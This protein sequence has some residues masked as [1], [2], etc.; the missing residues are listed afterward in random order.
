VLIVSFSMGL[1]AVLIA[2]GM[3][4]LYARRIVERFEWKGGMIAKL[5][6][7]SPVA[8]VLFGGIIAVQSA[9][10]GKLWTM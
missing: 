4:M 7:A 8:I 3:T 5:Q 9:M 6:L 2:I 1:A 10:T